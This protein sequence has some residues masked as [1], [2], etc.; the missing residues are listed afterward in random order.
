MLLCALQEV[1]AVETETHEVFA[2]N[3]SL[4]KQQAALNAEVG[5]HY[6]LCLTVNICQF[7]N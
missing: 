5:L 7:S 1:A 3:Q 6:L 4:N 2:E